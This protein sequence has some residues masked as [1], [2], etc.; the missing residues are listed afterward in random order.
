M[1]VVRWVGVGGVGVS[2]ELVF[3]GRVTR[4]FKEDD[5]AF[6]LHSAAVSFDSAIQL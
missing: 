5:Y 1:V 4:Q 2:V 6:Y 3:G